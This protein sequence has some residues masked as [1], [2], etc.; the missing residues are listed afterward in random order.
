MRPEHVRDR[1]QDV[2]ALDGAV[3]DGAVPLPRPLDDQRH[4]RDVRDVGGGERAPMSAGHERIALVGRQHDQRLVVR[5]GA[6]HAL[7]QIAD[8]PIGALE[9]QE[10]P[11]ELLRREPVVL[12]RVAVGLEPVRGQDNSHHP[13]IASDASDLLGGDLR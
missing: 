11:L 5:S 7:D 12:P 9:L 2:H 13:G 3:I 10:M 1:G 8:Q 4:E 6:A